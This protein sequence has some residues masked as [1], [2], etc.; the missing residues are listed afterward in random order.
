MLRAVCTFMLW[1]LPYVGGFAQVTQQAPASPTNSSYERALDFYYHHQYAETIHLT[2][3]I[4][5]KNPDHYEAYLLRGMAREE[6][7]DLQGALTDY[8][9]TLH[10]HPGL[11][12]STF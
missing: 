3:Q 5:A 8:R 2:Q 9:I 11:S 4:V 10:L 6:T 7:G 1:Y 12:G